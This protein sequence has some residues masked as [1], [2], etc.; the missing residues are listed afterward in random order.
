MPK[1]LIW[2]KLEKTGDSPN[3]RLGHTLVEMDKGVFVLFGGLDNKRKN[4][5]I[6]PNNQVFTLKINNKGV[7]VWMEI[8]CEGD[9]IP[10]ARSNHAACRIGGNM[11]FVFGGLYQS[12]QR[13]NDVHI[14][15]VVPGQKKYQWLQPENQ[16]PLKG[17]PKNTE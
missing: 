16:K 17:E 15:K 13:F 10:L 11:M 8:T 9:Q 5:K 14:L 1:P 3:A 6:R 7:A 2:K 4:G 12:N